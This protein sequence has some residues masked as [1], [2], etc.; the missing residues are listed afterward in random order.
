MW[1]SKIGRVFER[2]PLFRKHRDLA[3]LVGI[4]LT[5]SVASSLCI[6]PHSLSYFNE[7]V[8]GPKNGGKHMLDSN[9]DCGQDLRYLKAWLDVH[10]QVKLDGSAYQCS[11]PQPLTGIPKVPSPPP[12]PPSDSSMTRN[13]LKDEVGPKPDWYALSA[14]YL[15]SRDSRY[16]YFVDHF[17]PVAFAGYS[18]CIYRISPSEV[19]RVR[20]QLGLVEL[21]EENGAG[22]KV[23]KTRS[24]A[25]NAPIMDGRVVS[26]GLGI[27]SPPRYFPLRLNQIIRSSSIIC[28]RYPLALEKAPAVADETEGH[29][30]VDGARLELS[31]RAAHCGSR[32]NY[33]FS[34]RQS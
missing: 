6:Y 18:I 19:N 27:A 4:A 26:T 9:F 13:Y 14:N 17:E 33:E 11:Y 12:G 29:A 22:C 34:R 16:R 23:Q 1:I 20:R 30:S 8:G 10:P 3:A 25:L 15:Y 2:R 31:P 32:R 24:E 28:M 21:P 5:W 7:L